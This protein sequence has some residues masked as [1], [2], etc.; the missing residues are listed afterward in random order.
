[1]K[2]INL[3][4]LVSAL[5]VGSIVLTGCNNTSTAQNTDT[6]VNTTDT[7]QM[8]ILTGKVIVTTNRDLKNVDETTV[9]AYNLNTN[10]TY[11]TTAQSDGSYS[12]TLPEGNYQVIAVSPATTL[13]GIKLASVERN[14]KTVV[15]IVLQA[16]GNIKGQV[17]SKYYEYTFVTIPGTSYISSVDDNGNF[18]LINVPAGEEVIRFGNYEAR[19]NVVGGETV[20]V[21][22]WQYIGSVYNTQTLSA[23]MLKYKGLKFYY[24]GDINNIDNN[25][26]LTDENNNTIPLV[27]ELD[28]Y[29]NNTNQ[30]SGYIEIKTKDIIKPG[31]YY[32]S[33]KDNYSNFTQKINATNQIVVVD[34][35]HAE[36]GFFT[37]KLG[38]AFST[39]PNEFNSSLITISDSDGNTLQNITVKQTK[40]PNFYEIDGDFDPTK[41]YS[42]TFDSS[43]QSDGI[44]YVGANDNISDDGIYV[45]NVSVNNISVEN[46]TNVNPAD[47]IY[48][49]IDNSDALDLK[50][51][52]VTLNGKEYNITSLNYNQYYNDYFHDDIVSTQISFKPDLQYATE[53]NLTISANDIYGKKV[54][55][56][57]VSFATLTPKVVGV[58]PYDDTGIIDAD[59]I[60]DE[61]RY[62]LLKAYFNIPDVDLTSGQ[63]T[64]HDDT[65]NQDIPTT[66]F[67][68]YS[69]SSRNIYSVNIVT[70]Y[71]AAF[72]PESLK[73][74]TTYTMTVSGFKTKDGY[75]IADKTYTF[76]TGSKQLISYSVHN[77]QFVDPEYLNNSLEFFFFGGLSDEQK[78]ELKNGISIT[79]FDTALKTDETH[80][81]PEVLF[82]D[83]KFGTRMVIAFT[84]DPGRSYEINIP[85]DIAQE[86][87]TNTKLEF[88][89]I[90]NNHIIH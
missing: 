36:G 32:L 65:N 3:S 62:G 52:K 50:T 83:N 72:D 29:Y 82:E 22:E 56:K 58:S 5:L 75:P 26:K 61:S 1:M 60:I 20:E 13:K 17:P 33:F 76:T 77:A 55:D 63:I 24:N 10:K 28:N 67:N 90:I 18:E 7:I 80:P 68:Y 42:V 86:Y 87:N 30:Y 48:F 31:E 43:I 25:I 11:Q 16:A 27:F 81:V 9:V 6:S 64:L 79:S 44:V 34:I 41:K 14:I 70:D 78:N 57:T 88:M 23:V 46:N 39:M 35:S 71:M 45:G 38:V 19:V 47:P 74:D 84:I 53:Y 66:P 4:I 49:N 85:S 89:T 69:E 8:G 2:K 54:L 40:Y 59:T 73:P 51:L 21:G 37:R 12:L 15:D